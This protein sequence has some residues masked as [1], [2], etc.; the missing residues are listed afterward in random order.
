M[1]F[2]GNL[3]IDPRGLIFESYRIDG[4]TI[5]ECRMIFL[6]WALA[7]SKSDLSEDINI[8]LS[9]YQVKFD[10]H[11]MTTVLRAGLSKSSNTGRRG[12]RSGRL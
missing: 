9:E 4:I 2:K 11:P 3:S 10:D 6:D 8:L 12:G 1:V 5:E 7:G